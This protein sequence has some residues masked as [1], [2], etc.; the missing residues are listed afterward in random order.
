MKRFEALKVISDTLKNELVVSTTGMISRELFASKDRD[1]NFYMLGSMGLASP[2]ALGISLNKPKK[3]IVA[4]EGDGSMLM[5]LGIMTMVAA[6]KPKNLIIVVLD[7][8]CYE[9]TGGQDCIS[10]K[11]DLPRLV[12]GAACIKVAA[13]NNEKSLKE[14]LKYFLE[15]PG[16]SFLSIKIDSCRREGTSRIVHSPEKIKERFVKAAGLK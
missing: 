15:K 5:N 2:V 13:V 3:K 14:K 8:G 7:N 1:E 9:S 11:I 10:Q 16:P 6:G 12:N 4:I